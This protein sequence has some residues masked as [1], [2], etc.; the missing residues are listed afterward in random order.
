MSEFVHLHNH[1]HY[2]I[3]DAITTI[4]ELVEAAVNDGQK[5]I[6]LT[7][8][9]VMFGTIEF[10]ETCKKYNIKP[11]IGCEVYISNGSRFDKSSGKEK[12]RKKNYYHLLLLAKNEIGYKN[13]MKLSS[14]GHTEGFYYRPRIDKE[15]LEKYSDGLVC[16]SAC[17]GGVVSAH[18]RNN[19]Y[20]EAKKEAEYYKNLFGDDFYIEIQNHGINGDKEVLELA[21]KLATELDIK[22]VATNDIHY[23][24]KEDAV[25]HNVLLNIKDAKGKV[26]IDVNDLR[27]G[28]SEFYFKTQE[29]MKKLFSE[30]PEA[31]SNTCE[32]ADKCNLEIPLN[33][34]YMPV[35]PIL[36]DSLALTLG[37]YLEEL[38]LKGLEEKY[39]KIT[40]NISERANYELEIINKMDFPGYFLI[41]WDFIRAAKEL[42]V[43]VGPGR[44][45]AAGSIVAYALGIT[46][47]DPLKYNLLF[48]RF[49]N[50]ERISMPDIDIDFNDEQRDKVIDYVKNKYGD[51]AVA[52]IIIFGTLASR[53]VI[54]DVGRVLGIDL[55][56]VTKIT[57]Q[58][59]INFGKV[60]SIEEAMKK[61]SLQWV[62]DSPESKLQD[63]IKYAKE[64]RNKNRNTGTHAAGCSNISWRYYEYLPALSPLK[65]LQNLQSL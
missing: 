9:G 33:K 32:I 6:A 57:K 41:V 56:T 7:D 20:A 39:E 13:L 43:R 55:D 54:K 10:Y 48:E 29:E 58:F 23:L 30:F 35:F 60:E 24:N 12:T 27:Y 15:V 16:T 36:K 22:L 14:I 4:P 52:Q 65:N 61:A 51:N 50:P 11:I 26:E 64:A 2:S 34:L 18:L 46:N 42:G 40:P 25:A 44:G 1:S 45:S 37:E 8:H 3:L 62:A 49:L 21:P 17:L 19:N 28:T 5:A 63:L 47:V 59:E 38:V 31:I 53:A